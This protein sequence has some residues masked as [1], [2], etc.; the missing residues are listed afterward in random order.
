MGC[1]ILIPCIIFADEYANGVHK[2][3]LIVPRTRNV[4]EV[5]QFVVLLGMF[6]LVMSDR[7]PSKLGSFELCFIVYTLGWVL[8]QFVSTLPTIGVS[9]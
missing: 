4:L 6:L 3:R 1:S 9:A 2:Y 8:D 5:C 7:D